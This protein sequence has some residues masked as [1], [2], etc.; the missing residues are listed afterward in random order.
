MLLLSF[1]VLRTFLLYQRVG[2]LTRNGNENERGLER[3]DTDYRYIWRFS[4]ISSLYHVLVRDILSYGA[5]RR[6][7]YGRLQR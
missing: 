7:Y 5:V 2:Q 3:L 1:S 4:T 6:N